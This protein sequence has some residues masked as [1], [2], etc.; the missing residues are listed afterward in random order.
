[1]N[2]LR[3]A[4][5]A[6]IR[7][8]HHGEQSSILTES[9][10]AAL[11]TAAAPAAVESLLLGYQTHHDR[12]MNA[13]W[14]MMTVDQREHGEEAMADLLRDSVSGPM[15]R[16]RTA[17]AQLAGMSGRDIV[18]MTAETMRSHF[19]GVGARGQV[20][21]AEEDDRYV[22]S[23]DPCGSAGRARRLTEGSDSLLASPSAHVEGAHDWTWGDK[24]VCPYCAHCSFANEI[25]PMETIGRPKRIALYPT[26]VSEPCRWIVYKDPADIPAE[27]YERVGQ[28]GG[29]VAKSEGESA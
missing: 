24:G 13:T 29:T 1:M 6:S 15:V 21:V 10:R 28:T 20:E 12:L 25:L 17:H 11:G 18:L 5:L 2:E 9:A 22:L 14:A 26:N 27:Y 23:F 7:A 3:S 19:S 16:G 4:I 8:P